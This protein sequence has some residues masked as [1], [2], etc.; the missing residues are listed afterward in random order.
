MLQVGDT[1]T[2]AAFLAALASSHGYTTTVESY[3]DG[4]LI[5]EV[6]IETGEVNV[7][8]SNRDRRRLNFVAAENLW[9][10]RVDD[11]LS[12]H[13]VWLRAL[14]QI[15]AGSHAFPPVP[16]FAGK[17]LTTT[18]RRR[19]GR[20]AVVAVDP[21]WQINREAFETP[22]SA[23]LRTPIATLI[24]D[25]I[26][27]VFPQATLEDQTGSPATVPSLGL[28]WD[29]AVG[30]RGAAIDELAASIGAEVFARPTRVWPQGDFVLRPVPQL[31]SGVAA[32]TLTDGLTGVV[33]DDQLK[34]DGEEVVNRWIVTVEPTGSSGTLY[35]VATDNDPGS[36]TR[37]GGPMGKLVDFWSSPLIGTLAQASQA[38]TAK[39]ART[40]GT[41]NARDLKV[42][43]NPALEGGDL[44]AVQM[45]DEATVWHV[46]D[47]FVVPLSVSTA[48]MPIRTRAAVT[49]AD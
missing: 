34:L 42:I 45:G 46:V 41:G 16:V 18:R 25:L 35:A 4:E 17:L 10:A 29:A 14:V 23:L 28:L 44:I 48:T 36:P 3:F 31:G 12:P 2:H 33:T 22:R 38:A 39:L 7:M 32:W 21:F 1:A 13:G 43:T 8:S 49:T 24:R 15:S 20:L 26:V 30:S 19:S 9:P 11:L 37:Y 27:E 47:E 5:G 6:S 40:L